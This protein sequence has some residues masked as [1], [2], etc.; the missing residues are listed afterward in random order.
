MAKAK[1]GL[2]AS[3]LNRGWIG[4]ALVGLFVLFVILAAAIGFRNHFA[5]GQALGS[6]KAVVIALG[7][8]AGLVAAILIMVQFAL[9]GRWKILDRAFGIDRTMRCHSLLGPTAAV[10]A[11][12]HPLLL[13]GS[14][15]YKLGLLRL[16]LW[17]ELLGVLGLSALAAIVV[18]TLG[19]SFLGLRWQKWLSIHR[20]AFIGVVIVAAHSI[21]LGSG[22]KNGWPL[23]FWLALIAAY[24]LAFVLAKIVRPYTLA[25]RLFR[26]VEVTRLTHNT[27]SIVL[28][29][30]VGT[31]L[32]YL[33]GQFAFLKIFRKQGPT[34][35]HPFTICSAPDET[36]RIAF[37]IKESGDYTSTIGR[38]QLGE[39]A[40][41]HGAFGRFSYLRIGDFEHLILI[42]GG[43]G[44]T[45]MISTLRHMA[46]AG[47]E[48]P[49]TLI[50]S[51]RKK[52]DI[53]F[54]DELLRLEQILP[55]LKT[56]HVL[57]RQSDYQGS[58]G[59]LNEELLS[60]LLPEDITDSRVM[61]CGPVG[62]MKLVSNALVRMGMPRRRIHSE[63]FA[64]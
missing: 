14:G 55:G 63:R 64:L 2:T 49:V 13:Y 29:S 45:P 60:R 52:E 34:E 10:L 19:R 16:G 30:D 44:I 51:N 22:L 11:A 17:P 39:T 57:S 8:T 15:V 53:F 5:D 61:L 35:E 62:M 37:T 54:S 4:L 41:V 27:H 6:A 47:F 23:V 1:Q 7:K 25:R 33:P 12:L 26:V 48:K 38:I 28:Q 50:W 18:T 24:L 46:A 3:V 59:H 31:G 9:S 36:D 43:V 42:A 40:T 58:K 21:A 56:Y 20:L 32:N